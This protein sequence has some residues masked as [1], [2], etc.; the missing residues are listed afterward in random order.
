M[1]KDI[2]QRFA[3]GI[4]IDGTK[5]YA[6]KVRACSLKGAQFLEVYLKDGSADLRI[7]YVTIFPGREPHYRSWIDIF[8]IKDRLNLRSLGKDCY[9]YY[10]SDI[11]NA[12]LD[13]L[14][15]AL[16]PGDRIFIEYYCDPE[17]SCGLAMGIPPVLSRQGYK[18]F[19]LGFTWFKDWYFSEGGHEGG[20]KLQGEKPLDNLAKMKHLK[21]IKDE[22]Q[23]FIES[24]RDENA[25][26]Q[27]IKDCDL[28]DCGIT[29]ER[30]KYILKA[31]E[32]A[33]ELLARI[34][35]ELKESKESAL[36]KKATLV[37]Q[38]CSQ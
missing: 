8:C 14:C 25:K 13:A 18:L 30:R 38:G 37:Y 35:A 7:F 5:A 19:N 15:S 29:G 9:D 21:R 26:D 4:D 12:L 27:N 11:E 20:Q 6:R 28:I 31:R 17:T 3:E 23:S 1:L 36:P 22:V 34:D 10:D 16:G 24:A 32:R 33:K 2:I